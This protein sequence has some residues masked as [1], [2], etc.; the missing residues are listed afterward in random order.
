MGLSWPI[1]LV[2]PLDAAYSNVREVI[3]VSIKP[4]Q[5]EFTRMSVFRSWYAA[6]CAMLLT[7]HSNEQR[8]HSARA[9]KL[10]QLCLRY[11]KSDESASHKE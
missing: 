10:T 6:V 3:A 5:I 9:N 11:L 2:V 4:G 1:L 8:S 7:L